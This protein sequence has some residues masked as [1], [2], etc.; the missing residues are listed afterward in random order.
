MTARGDPP[1]RVPT[2]ACV[3]LR[4]LWDEHRR[5]AF[6]AAGTGRVAP[7]HQGSFATAN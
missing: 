5:D 1:L 7:V 4:R 6:P 2:E 3:R